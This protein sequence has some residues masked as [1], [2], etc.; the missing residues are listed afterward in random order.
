MEIRRQSEKGVQLLADAEQKL[1]KLELDAERIEAT[2]L[3]DAQGTVVDRQSLSKLASYEAREA[4]GLARV[5]VNRIKT[6]LKH[7]SESMMAV[8]HAGKMVEITYKTAGIG[9]R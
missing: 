1:L 7:L 3:L 6:K 4:A 8:M 5:E 9:E 2:A